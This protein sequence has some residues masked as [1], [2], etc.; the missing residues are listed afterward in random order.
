MEQTHNGRNSPENSP[1][2]RWHRSRECHCQGNV[3]Q[4]LSH[5]KNIERFFTAH[6]GYIPKILA[7]TEYFVLVD[8]A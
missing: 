1:P 4:T 7:K 3:Q 2:H 8:K 5:G 6:W